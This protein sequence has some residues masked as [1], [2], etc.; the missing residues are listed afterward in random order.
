MVKVSLKPPGAQ[1]VV[2]LWDQVSE[3]VLH[4]EENSALSAWDC[5]HVLAY[6]TLLEKQMAFWLVN[7]T[8]R[9][10]LGS[11][12]HIRQVCADSERKGGCCRKHRARHRLTSFKIIRLLGAPGSLSRLSVQL[13]V[14]AQDMV[15]RFCEFKP[16]VGLCAD[17]TK[18]AWDS[19]SLS[20]SLPLPHSCS[21]C[22]SRDKAKKKICLNLN[23]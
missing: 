17:R 10:T 15:S 23:Q 1:A 5:S 12:C 11:A 4:Q 16:R 20:L 18:L 6:N 14:S 13:L 8:L 21:L 19:L 7:Q 22:L 9:Q 3:D 2:V